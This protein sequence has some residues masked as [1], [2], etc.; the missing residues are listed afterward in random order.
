VTLVNEISGGF[1]AC[2][3]HRS[4]YT[5]PKGGSRIAVS[6]KSTLINFKLMVPC[7]VIQCE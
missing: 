5:E 1:S 3:F 7:N 2:I 4:S 6:D